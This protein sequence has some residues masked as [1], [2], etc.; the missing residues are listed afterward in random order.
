MRAKH[1]YRGAGDVER[2]MLHKIHDLTHFP[3]YYSLIAAEI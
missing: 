2:I 1:A 3:H